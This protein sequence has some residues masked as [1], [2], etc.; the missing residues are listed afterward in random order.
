VLLRA[1]KLSLTDA[2]AVLEKRHAP[3]K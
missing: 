2:I 1:K 3:K